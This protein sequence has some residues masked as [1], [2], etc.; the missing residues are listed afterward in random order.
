[1]LNLLYYNTNRTE[2]EEREETR[3]LPIAIAVF[4]DTYSSLPP[5][6]KERSIGVCE[7][8][9]I[10]CYGENLQTRKLRI[11]IFSYQRSVV[12]LAAW[13]SLCLMGFPVGVLYSVCVCVFMGMTTPRCCSLATLTSSHMRPLQ[14]CCVEPLPHCPLLNK[15]A[16]G[17]YQP[18]HVLVCSCHLAVQLLSSA[19][20]D[21]WKVTITRFSVLT[22][23]SLL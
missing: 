23:A 6:Q 2:G 10:H 17:V 12:L 20:T 7:D 8:K 16:T 3:P 21:I 4:F 15:K 1:M 22:L 11:W 14:H 9:P 19:Y 18:F 13:V 5:V